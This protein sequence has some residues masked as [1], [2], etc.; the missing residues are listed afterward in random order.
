MGSACECASLLG[1]LQVLDDP[2]SQGRPPQPSSAAAVCTRLAG[3]LR[4]AALAAA[5]AA[6]SCGSSSAAAARALAGVLGGI[7]TAAFPGPPS[8][9]ARPSPA[10][11]QLLQLAG[12]LLGG[13]PARLPPAGPQREGV[14]HAVAAVQ[15]FVGRAAD[16]AAP[17]NPDAALAVL[18]GGTAAQ[19]GYRVRA[20]RPTAWAAVHLLPHVAAAWRLLAEAGAGDVLTAVAAV[21]GPCA[22]MAWLDSRPPFVVSDGLGAAST[23]LS[24]LPHAAKCASSLGSPDEVCDW[25]TAAEAALGL[26][27]DLARLLADL[28]SGGHELKASTQEVGNNLLTF[29][30]N[31]CL[32]LLPAR[33]CGSAGCAHAHHA[34]PAALAVLLS[35]QPPGSRV[36]AKLRRLHFTACRA[37]FWVAVAA[38]PEQGS[39]PQGKGATYRLHNMARTCFA[40]LQAATLASRAPSDSACVLGLGDVWGGLQQR[41]STSPARA[42]SLAKHLPL[43]LPAL[44][45]GREVQAMALAQLAAMEAV[46]LGEPCLSALQD[47]EYLAA[48]KPPASHSPVLA[49]VAAR[50]LEL[51]QACQG[52]RARWLGQAAA[53]LGDHRTPALLPHAS[54][55]PAGDGG[56]APLGRLAHP[57]A[58]PPG[59]GRQALAACG[60]R[61][62]QQRRPAGVAHQRRA[63]GRPRADAGVLCCACT[64]WRMPAACA[65]DESRSSVLS[66]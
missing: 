1:Q 21:A 61:G 19:A 56:A 60:G 44:H 2:A 28:Q 32:S 13:L 62:A 41:C 48:C 5:N 54:P 64:G 31:S 4:Q 65:F 45:A 9:S 29:V 51:V 58:G 24:R 6:L 66:C 46:P 26:L 36:A 25:C 53:V 27:P 59:P 50:Q 18:S 40:V 39:V 12:Q 20:D 49:V 15:C 52:R 35:S 3:P 42:S 43:R 30:V 57:H 7:L 34:D 37:L 33:A 22:P 11:R 23:A 17:I 38:P 55:L 16:D 63:A 14:L 47:I 8:P 10:S